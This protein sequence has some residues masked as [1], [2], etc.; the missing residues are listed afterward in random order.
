MATKNIEDFDKQLSIIQYYVIS[1]FFIFWYFS[2]CVPIKLGGVKWKLSLENTFNVFHQF[3][4]CQMCSLDH[5]SIFTIK[6][7]CYIAYIT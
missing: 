3:I 7:L 2:N 5:S 1:L 6:I 4:F